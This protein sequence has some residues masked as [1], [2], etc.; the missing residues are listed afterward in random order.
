M[1][2]DAGYDNEDTQAI[3]HIPPPGEEADAMDQEG[4]DV[5]IFDGLGDDLARATGLPLMDSRTRTDRV[6]GRAAHWEKQMDNLIQAYLA[7][8]S[9][10]RGDHFPCPAPSEGT[11]EDPPFPS[12][13]IETLDSYS[14][15]LFFSGLSNSTNN[16]SQHGLTPILSPSNR[17]LGKRDPYSTWLPRLCSIETDPS[18]LDS[19]T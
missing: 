9:Q 19:D 16:F 11:P 14:I 8:R 15:Y 5:S 1:D 4:G 10:D 13:I 18:Y 3:G 12:F 7:Y 17:N 2:L 6:E